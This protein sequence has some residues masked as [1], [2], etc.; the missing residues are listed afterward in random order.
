MGTYKLLDLGQVTYL[1]CACL[2]SIYKL[3]RRI[4]ICVH[5]SIENY[6]AYWC[7]NYPIFDS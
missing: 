6:Y 3:W 1:F 2:N 4:N 7:L 5:L